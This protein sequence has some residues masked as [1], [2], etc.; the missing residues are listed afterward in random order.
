MRSCR[1][2]IDFVRQEARSAEADVAFRWVGEDR[3]EVY[4]VRPH[5]QGL[6]E[7]DAWAL[8][9]SAKDAIALAHG[10]GKLGD[11]LRA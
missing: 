2:T 9:Q 6:T 8:A 10:S 1:W 11:G 4:M 3:P 7:R 5:R